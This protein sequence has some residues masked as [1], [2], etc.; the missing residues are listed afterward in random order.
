MRILSKTVL[1]QGP[2]RMLGLA[3]GVFFGFRLLVCLHLGVFG[4]VVPGYSGIIDGHEI[5]DPGDPVFYSYLIGENPYF[6]WRRGIQWGNQEF[7]VVH[8]PFVARSHVTSLR[9]KLSNC[10]ALWRDVDFLLR[11]AL[12]AAGAG[13]GAVLLL[14]ADRIPRSVPR[15]WRVILGFERPR[16][17]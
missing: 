1:L 2:W 17:E 15:H 7:S 5:P 13:A 16:Y 11:I 4:R 10:Y 14:L 9:P 8:S 3:L 6:G 12:F